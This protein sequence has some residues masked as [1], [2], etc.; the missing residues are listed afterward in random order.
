MIGGIIRYSREGGA[1]TNGTPRCGAPRV[2]V[3]SMSHHD[4]YSELLATAT[5]TVRGTI[6]AGCN[7]LS[8]CAKAVERVAKA[9]MCGSGVE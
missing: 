6:G 2:G 5:A 1:Q 7:A 8:A 3:S 4:R 9:R